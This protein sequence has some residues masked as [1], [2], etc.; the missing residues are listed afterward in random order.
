M[1][2]YD[3]FVRNSEQRKPFLKEQKEG[4]LTAGTIEVFVGV[5][6]IKF[7]KFLNRF[8]VTNTIISCALIVL[9]IAGKLSGDKIINAHWPLAIAEL[10]LAVITAA[11]I[12]CVNSHIMRQLQPIFGENARDNFWRVWKHFSGDVGLG[13]VVTAVIVAGICFIILRAIFPTG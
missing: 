11:L 1:P 4:K 13:G 3:K 5:G 7:S 12:G 2:N 8:A 6:L 10:S 9:A